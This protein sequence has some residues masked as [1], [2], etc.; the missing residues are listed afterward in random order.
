MKESGREERRR[1]RARAPG[2]FQIGWKESRAAQTPA[3]DRQRT[4]I[5]RPIIT[6]YIYLSISGGENKKEG[7][8]EGDVDAENG[9][10]TVHQVEHVRAAS[11]LAFGPLHTRNRIARFLNPR[12][13]AANVIVLKESPFDKETTDERM[14]GRFRSGGSIGVLFALRPYY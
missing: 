2:N 10:R 8:L 6:E 11:H 9:E 1:E 13:T 3:H 14:L 7:I 5:T 12:M 4:T